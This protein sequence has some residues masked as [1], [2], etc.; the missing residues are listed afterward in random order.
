MQNMTYSTK[1]CVLTSSKTW[2]KIGF[3]N[4][5]KASMLDTLENFTKSSL[6]ISAYSEI[7]FVN[8]SSVISFKT[9][10]FLDI[11]SFLEVI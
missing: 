9:L 5:F 2:R 8:Q 4:S 7:L 1:C 3:L 10:S 11:L 6:V